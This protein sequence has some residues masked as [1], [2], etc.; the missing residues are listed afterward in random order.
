MTK[1]ALI[2]GITGQDGSYLAELLLKKEYKVLGVMRRLSLFNTERIDHLYKKYPLK[3]FDTAYGDLIDVNSLRKN[4]ED[5]MPDEVYNLAAQSHVRISFDLPESTFQYNAN[6]TLYLLEA[7]KR[8]KPK[9]KFYQACSSE[10][11]GISPPLQNEKT[12]FLPQSIYGVSKVTSFYITNYYRRAFN[13][14]ACTGI[15][16]NHES[17]RRGTNFVTRKITLGL[18][19][20]ITG[21]IK[22]LELGNLS[23]LRDWGFAGDYVEAIWRIMQQKKPDNFVIAT[24]EHY[25]VEDFVK[26][27]FELVE[28]DWKKFVKTDVKRFKRP[29]EVP[30]L[31]G[32]SS[33]AR[34]ILKWKPKVKFKELCEM[35]VKNDLQKHN[36]TLNQAREK[37]KKL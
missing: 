16:F 15:L 37:A 34:K 5:F 8:V 30:D 9:C 33:K 31:Q 23:A 28:L 32:D 27:C 14:F 29:A 1:K 22:H 19:K 35:M 7:I 24:G 18:A 21:E 25:S 2:L 26:L 4:I 13:L 36:L 6:S 10:M 11:F 12:E 17:P 20:I 3:R